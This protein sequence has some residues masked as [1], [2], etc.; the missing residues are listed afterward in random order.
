MMGK[1]AVTLFTCIESNRHYVRPIHDGPLSVA[2]PLSAAQ[3]GARRL[4]C[5]AV[6]GLAYTLVDCGDPGLR[7][8]C[9]LRRNAS[10]PGT[11]RERRLPGASAVS[12]SRA[13]HGERGTP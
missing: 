9:G 3:G 6:R 10:F 7:R 5:G 2:A 1:D 13:L 12:R 11:D 8:V 4:L